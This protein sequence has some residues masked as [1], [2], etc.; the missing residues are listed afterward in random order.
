MVIIF[1][2]LKL[3][4]WYG[5]YTSDAP[6]LKCLCQAQNWSIWSQVGG[7]H[8]ISLPLHSKGQMQRT[9]IPT[10]FKCSFILT[11]FEILSAPSPMAFYS[12]CTKPPKYTLIKG[13]TR[14]MEKC[15]CVR[16]CVPVFISHSG[17]RSRLTGYLS[18][19]GKDGQRDHSAVGSLCSPSTWEI[20]GCIQ[21]VNSYFRFVTNCSHFSTLS[22]KAWPCTSVLCVMCHLL[23]KRLFSF[24]DV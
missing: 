20:N 10:G 5:C 16:V 18:Q 9:N 19:R 1:N 17:C 24:S 14:G 11:I 21:N 8:G 12:T 15:V 6:V 13:K 7:W 4:A 2:I 22:I 23:V 3:N